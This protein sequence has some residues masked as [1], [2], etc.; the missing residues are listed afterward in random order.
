ML[1]PIKAEA[2]VE[3]VPPLGLVSKYFLVIELCVSGYLEDTR[4]AEK[5]VSWTRFESNFTLMRAI[6][7]TEDI[8][9][10]GTEAAQIA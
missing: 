7:Q 2:S 5:G 1:I 10:I 6:C 4:R 9:C 3:L 8:S